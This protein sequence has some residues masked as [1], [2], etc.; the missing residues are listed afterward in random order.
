MKAKRRPSGRPFLHLAS[1]A[2]PSRSNR[3]MALPWSRSPTTSRASRTP[4]RP[5]IDFSASLI[6][7]A[8]GRNYRGPGRR[9]RA[10][11]PTA[12]LLLLLVPLGR[13][14]AAHPCVSAI[15]CKVSHAKSFLVFQFYSA[16]PET[17]CLIRTCAMTHGVSPA[18]LGVNW[19][20]T[21]PIAR[22]QAHNLVVGALLNV[23]RACPRTATVRHPCQFLRCLTNCLSPTR[24]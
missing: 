21:A 13:S 24:W 8:C 23:R 22:A 3:A 7:T 15:S 19:V 9:P 6:V 17:P 4:C 11:R 10:S 12:G 1:A 16:K 20:Q 14:F 2:P 5:T 18:Q